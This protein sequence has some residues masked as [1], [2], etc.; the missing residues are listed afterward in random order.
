MSDI[1]RK[2][3]DHSKNVF[4]NIRN[5][6]WFNIL[7]QEPVFLLSI[8]VSVLYSAAC[9]PESLLSLFL[10][11]TWILFLLRR[12]AC[13]ILF[14]ER[15]DFDTAF[16]VI[17]TQIWWFVRRS[18]IRQQSIQL[19]PLQGAVKGLLFAEGGEGPLRPGLGFWSFKHFSV[20]NRVHA[21]N[22]QI[23]TIISSL[24]SIRRDKGG[25]PAPIWVAKCFTFLGAVGEEIHTCEQKT[26]KLRMEASSTWPAACVCAQPLSHVRLV[27]TLWIVAHQ[28][29]LSVRFSRQEY[30]SGLPYPPPGNL[31]GLGV[32]NYRQCKE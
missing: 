29:P 9:I 31:P 7:T 3:E 11:T 22:M 12:R 14:P 16:Y 1:Q 6:V 27:V 8:F 17:L 5:Y 32:K 21:R 26:E 4:N 13:W 18:C 20:W 10:K 28:A 2:Y 30:W 15:E 25:H 24:A 23:A 19:L